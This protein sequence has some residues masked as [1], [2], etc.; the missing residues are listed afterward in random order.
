MSAELV[1]GAVSL[2]TLASTFE[3]ALQLYDALVVSTQS[4]GRESRLLAIKIFLEQERFDLYAQYVGIL[5]PRERPLVAQLPAKNQDMVR[6]VAEEVT[7]LLSDSQ[8]LLQKYGILQDVDDE[9]C[10]KT[11]IP[12]MDSSNQSTTQE[13]AQTSVNSGEAQRKLNLPT[14]RL[15]YSKRVRWVWRDGDKAIKLH[16]H[17]RDLN[18]AL[19][20]TL[21]SFHWSSLQKALPSFVLPGINDIAALMDIKDGMKGEGDSNL[22]ADCAEMRRSSILALPDLERSEEWKQLTI[23]GS[24]SIL[25]TKKH[26]GKGWER[27]EARLINGKR[28]V[29]VVIEYKTIRADLK[30]E[31]KFL[32]KTRIRQAAYQLLKPRHLDVCLLQC[33]GLTVDRFNPLRYGIV[34]KLPDP[35]FTEIISL[36]TLLADGNTRKQAVLGERFALALA[37]S[38]AVL[39]WHASGWL[40]KGINTD[41]IVFIRTKSS[42][43]DISTPKLLGF[44]S[45]RPDDPSEESLMTILEIGI[46]D[47]FR[48]PGYYIPTENKFH[49]SYDYYSLGV[50][51][52]AIGWWDTVEN[53]WSKFVLRQPLD[54]KNPR[55]WAEFLVERAESSLGFACGHI[56]RDVVLRCLRVD[57]GLTESGEQIDWSSSH[58]DWQK[59]FLF[60]VVN[61][62]ARCT[63]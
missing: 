58:T 44:G 41:N 38:Y 22:V 60:T 50:V 1:I 27:S 11:S 34:L 63:A 47:K 33:V 35:R 49:R 21:P 14:S 15:K 5:R 59:A 39:Q 7:T 56:Y 55:K 17:L 28:S 51:L 40:H 9:V 32:A 8:T 13:S 36:E 19:W 29:P 4:A 12:A 57:F 42:F 24:Q 20:G 25:L 46:V 52:L 54:T 45:A 10:R 23:S 6:L 62:L 26:S 31:E 48:Y 43:P 2:V 30:D 53:L 3:T 37:L 18:D 61:E 16:Q